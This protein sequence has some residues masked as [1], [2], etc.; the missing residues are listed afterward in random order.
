MGCRA[1]EVSPDRFDKW[2]MGRVDSW[3]WDGENIFIGA[4][5]F[6]LYKNNIEF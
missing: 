3:I 2:T 4:S 6:V 1:S 5:Y